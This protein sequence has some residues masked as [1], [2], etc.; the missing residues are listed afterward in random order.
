MRFSAL[1]GDQTVEVDV[2][3]EG[4]ETFTVTLEERNGESS[5]ETLKVLRRSGNRWTVE[6]ENR[7]EDFLVWPEGD[8][9]VVQWR[10]STF[11]VDILPLRE[12]LRRQTSSREAAGAAVLKAQMPG[13]VVSVLKAPGETV[14]SGEGLVIIE[15]MKMQ[16]EVK[17]PKS[18]TVSRCGVAEGGTVNAG[19]LLFEIE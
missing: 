15:S 19:D 18:G 8:R 7:V 4:R 13:R 14:E 5:R 12:R 17:S 11:E 10:R 3:A 16:N 2:T 1:D 6:V 9:T